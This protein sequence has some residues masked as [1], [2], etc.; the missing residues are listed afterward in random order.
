MTLRRRQIVVAA[1]LVV[2]VVWA[3]L[4]WT[5]STATPEPSVGPSPTG[6]I[7][8]EPVTFEPTEDG[9]PQP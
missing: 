2:L 7:G 5:G 8:S 4:I 9:S 1:G 6:A 3:L